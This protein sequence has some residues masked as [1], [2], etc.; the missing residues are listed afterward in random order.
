VTTPAWLAAT[1]GQRPQPGQVNQFLGSH[2]ATWV[3][4][5]NTQQAAQATGTGLYV[6]TAGAYLTQEF[7]TG[8]AQTVIGN[9]HL[10]ISAVG[11][12]PVTAAITPLQVALY[13]SSSGL[14]TGPV[15]AATTL[16]EQYV[17]SGG[18][19]LTVPLGATGLTPSAPY[20]IVVA[21]A[22]SSTAYYAWQRSNQ[23]SGAA[24]SPDG[25]TWTAQPYGL[26]YQVYD[27][28][29]TSGPPLYVIEDSGARVTQLSYNTAGQLTGITETTAA[30]GGAA[31]Y[32][33]RTLTYSNGLPIGVS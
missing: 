32:S 28:A 9:L 19:M 25:V 18:F 4:S 21:A 23:T 16:A 10:Q 15:L 6:S 1:A 26:M 24:T 33:T 22:G 20:Q 5:G 17:Y 8:A 31:F 2:S 11:G 3:Y 14:P 13:A 30:Q 12:S 29:G 7:T 27:L